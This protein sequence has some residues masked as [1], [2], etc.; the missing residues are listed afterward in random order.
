M[1]GSN[2]GLHGLN[3]VGLK[4]A[5]CPG[6]SVARLKEA[7]RRFCKQREALSAFQAWLGEQAEQANDPFLKT[8]LEFITPR[9]GRGYARHGGKR[10]ED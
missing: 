7:Y 3:R 6:D 8:W 5:G 10:D 1:V 2:D 4:R 9:S